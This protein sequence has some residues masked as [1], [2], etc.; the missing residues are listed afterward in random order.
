MNTMLQQHAAIGL[1][2]N[3]NH[4]SHIPVVG[5]LL[6]SV[7]R[8]ATALET[9]A[10]GISRKLEQ[11]LTNLIDPQIVEDAP[12][13]ENIFTGDAINRAHL[14]RKRVAEGDHPITLM[15]LTRHV[16]PN[17]RAVHLTPYSGGFM[18]VIA[19]DKQNEGEPKNI[20]FAVMATRVNIKLAVVVDTD[21]DIYQP[22]DILWAL[23]TRVDANRDL[24]IVPYAQGMENDPTTGALTV[25]TPRWL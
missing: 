19:V 6:G 10:S 1:F 4:P 2:E 25:P 24:F 15:N 17:V 12:F 21:V 11:A 5:G 13:K 18:A 20:A 16:S 8:I 3:V 22:S 23:A 7:D 14:H 9:D